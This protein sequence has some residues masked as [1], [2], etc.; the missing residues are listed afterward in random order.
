MKYINEK[1][2]KEI[3][4]E[5]EKENFEGFFNSIFLTF[6]LLGGFVIIVIG[7]YLA[8]EIIATSKYS[9]F[10]YLYSLGLIGLALNY[11][12]LIMDN[13][14]LFDKGKKEKNAH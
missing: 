10:K 3:L 4:K 2:L 1:K 12:Y 9:W 7:T 11:A 13:I 5:R 6:G 8:P 14:G